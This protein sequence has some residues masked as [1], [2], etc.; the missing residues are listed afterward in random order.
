MIEIRYGNDADEQQNE[1]RQTKE[2]QKGREKR[3]KLASE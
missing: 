1:K 3:E 2:E